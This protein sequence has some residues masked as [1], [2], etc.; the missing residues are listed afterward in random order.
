MDSH[1]SEILERLNQVK[2]F[3]YFKNR[4]MPEFVEANVSELVEFFPSY[5]ESQ[6]EQILSSASPELSSVLGWYARKLAGRAVRERSRKDV[7]NGLIALAIAA[8]N[9]DFRDLMSPLALLHNSALRLQEDPRILF[10]EVSEISAQSA[11]NLLKQ[12]LARSPGLKSIHTFGFEE[13]TG[14]LG[15]DY[16]PYPST[17]DQR[18]FRFAL[19]ARIFTRKLLFHWKPTTWAPDSYSY[20]KQSIGSRFAAKF[21][22]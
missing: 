11:R 21:A 16:V 2:I 10:E 17:G 20:L 18:P 19:A 12:F 15:F 14:P 13:G 3:N 8:Q 22:G 7:L 6:R 1:L 9:W 5:T 4:A